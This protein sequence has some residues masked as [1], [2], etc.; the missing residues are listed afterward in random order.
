VVRG[1][2]AVLFRG[3]KSYYSIRCSAKQ[4]G[5]TGWKAVFVLKPRYKRIK[6]VVLTAFREAVT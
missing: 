6:P 4:A 1:V 3:E 5:V 2:T